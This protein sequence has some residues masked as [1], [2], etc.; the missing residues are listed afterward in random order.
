[1]CSEIVLMRG[2]SICFPELS[3]KLHLLQSTVYS[4]NLLPLNYSLHLLK[5]LAFWSESASFFSYIS[6]IHRF[7]PPWPLSEGQALFFKA[8]LA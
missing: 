8:S 1:M 2:H 4:A 5:L 6:G 3:S 7:R